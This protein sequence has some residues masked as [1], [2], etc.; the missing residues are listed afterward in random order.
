MP[1]DI[2]VS[3]ASYNTRELLRACLQSLLERHREGEATLEI[4]VA[5][6]GSTDGSPRMVASEFP[7]VRLV[8][9]GGN[10]GYGRANNMALEGAK[11]RYF[12][13]FNSDAEVEPSA[14]AAMRDF[15]DAHPEAG[16]VGPQLLWPDGRL[17]TSWGYDP[18]PLDVFHEQ[19]FL[20]GIAGR[21]PGARHI[22]TTR[23][24]SG[25][26]ASDAP[27]E[28]E[29]IC[30]ACQFVRAA[31]YRQLGGYDP[32]YFMYG[33]DVDLNIRLRQAGWKIYFLPRARVL[34]HLGA[35]SENDWRQ[36]ARMVVSYNQSRYFHF[37][38]HEGP[39]AGRWIKIVTSAG[40]LLRLLGWSMVSLA[41][42]GA[43]TKV[44][45]FRQVWRETR[46][47]HL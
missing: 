14:L 45:L 26:T 13:A 31:A 11:G 10:I 46:A 2:S 17:Q 4:V 36:R 5:D 19:T 39:W 29:Q 22:D 3:I 6:N 7:A 21:L 23:I 16:A 20:G 37:T 43:R 40:A 9:T 30:G 18:R 12:C 44:K 1:C 15:L 8:A 32:A 35:S 47:M 34:H 33:E 38:R 25:Q 41:W 42:P 27:R 28:V 24:A